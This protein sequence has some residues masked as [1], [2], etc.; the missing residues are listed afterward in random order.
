MS[1]PPPKTIL[2]KRAFEPPINAIVDRRNA[3]AYLYRVM[4]ASMREDYDNAKA[5]G[6]P[7]THLPR[8]ATNIRIAIKQTLGCFSARNVQGGKNM[9]STC[10]CIIACLG[11]ALVVHT[12]D[13]SATHHCAVHDLHVEQT[14]HAHPMQT[15][16]NLSCIQK[17]RPPTCPSPM[18][19]TCAWEKIFSAALSDGK[20]VSKSVP[21]IR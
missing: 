13:G 14:R 11:E 15:Q 3:Q 21:A 20:S 17:L 5:W 8:V 4:G 18:P 16:Q 1:S 19:I 9:V 10:S 6:L 2:S 12:E 7:S